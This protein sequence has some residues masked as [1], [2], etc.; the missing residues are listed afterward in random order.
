MSDGAGY[1]VF[2]GSLPA[3]ISEEELKYVFQSYGDVKNIRILR[4][5]DR[6]GKGNQ[7]SGNPDSIAWVTYF[8]KEPC[9]DAIDVL[10]DQYKP[11][12]QTRDASE[13]KGND[14]LGS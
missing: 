5:E 7:G 2:V 11:N 8:E 4:A 14:E 12:A 3:D 10:N 9:E 1:Q 13:W 6:K